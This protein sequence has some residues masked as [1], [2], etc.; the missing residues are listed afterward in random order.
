MKLSIATTLLSIT[1][2]NAAFTTRPSTCTLNKGTAL[3]GYLDD[4][5]KDI[6]PTEEA[7]EKPAEAF[8]LQQEQV[9]RFGPGEW[10]D[11]VE[12]N[13]FDGGDGQMG[14]AG[15]GNVSLEKFGTDVQASVGKSKFRSAKN[16]W[17]TF[18]GYAEDLASS[19]MDIQRAQQLENWNN[20]QEVMAKKREA[21]FM[22]DE[23]DKVTESADA[24]WRTLAKFGV[25]RNQEFDLDETFGAVNAGDLEG[26]IE[27][28]SMM[29]RVAYHEFELKNEYMGFADF[30]A[31]FTPD[32]SV[33]WTITPTEGSLSSKEPVNF[34]VK[35]KPSQPGPNE[36]YLVIETEDFKKT[37]KLIGGTA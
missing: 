5:N 15:D 28:S 29:N 9:D 11:Y 37:Y 8:N 22:T 6:A 10:K 21:K 4:L 20:Q 36:G 13:E 26:V 18:T 30:R 23:F 19:G 7:E 14:V 25:E 32:T 2:A 3:F 12:F 31:A 33:D 1:I 24:D 16:A 34:I 35:F 17:G 27:L